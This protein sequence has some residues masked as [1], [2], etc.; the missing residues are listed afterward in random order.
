MLQR[1]TSAKM[2]I[3]IY[4]IRDDMSDSL[5]TI[6]YYCAHHSDE[7]TGLLCGSTDTSVTDDADGEAGCETREADAQAS[8]QLQ[9]PSEEG[10]LGI[11]C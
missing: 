9:E 11:H 6:F 2:R 8:S 4:R 1:L 3:R 10:H 5:H 7:Q